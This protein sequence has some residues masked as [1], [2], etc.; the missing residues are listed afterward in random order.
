MG[1]NTFNNATSD[2]TNC[3][4]SDTS[5]SDTYT[6]NY[7]DKSEDM[8]AIF[9][10]DRDIETEINKENKHCFQRQAIKHVKRSRMKH[11]KPHMTRRVM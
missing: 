6:S 1:P 2:N 8:D 3:H 9:D 5:Y 7:P 10:N 11:K 4:P